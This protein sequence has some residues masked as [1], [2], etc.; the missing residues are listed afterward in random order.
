MPSA[1]F[2]PHAAAR[3]KEQSPTDYEDMEKYLK[4]GGVIRAVFHFQPEP[5]IAF[6]LIEHDGTPREFYRAR[7][8]RRAGRGLQ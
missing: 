6:E 3:I 4:M 5:A 2:W 7:G 8:S 1:E